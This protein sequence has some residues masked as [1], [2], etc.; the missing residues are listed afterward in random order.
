MAIRTF[1]P[2]ENQHSMTDRSDGLIRGHEVCRDLLKH[3]G[4]EIG[5]HGLVMPSRQDKRLER[6][7]GRL[8]IGDGILKCIAGDHLGIGRAS[9][10][11]GPKDVLQEAQTL[12]RHHDWIG[13]RWLAVWGCENDLVPTRGQNLPRD[14][15]LG[16]IKPARWQGD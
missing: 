3:L 16:R 5:L 14:R 10:G 1:G 9:I 15:G 2:R 11:I 4:L 12:A 13:A 8:V 6:P 7:P